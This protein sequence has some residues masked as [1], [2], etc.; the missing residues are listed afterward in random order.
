MLD[1]IAVVLARDRCLILGGLLR[2]LFCV[3]LVGFIGVRSGLLRLWW[4]FGGGGIEGGLLGV[5]VAGCVAIVGAC[6]RGVGLVG[7]TLL[8]G[9]GGLLGGASLFGRAGLLGGFAVLSG[10][11]GTGVAQEARESETQEHHTQ[12][13]EG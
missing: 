9:S 8:L 5:R 1:A 7:G 11:A 3:V 13:H 6:I 12:A 4:G 10:G 2:G